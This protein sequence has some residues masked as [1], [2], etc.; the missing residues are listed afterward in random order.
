MNQKFI[1]L[2]TMSRSDVVKNVTCEM[3]PSAIIAREDE[4]YLT[5]QFPTLETLLTESIVG[6]LD[7]ATPH[8]DHCLRFTLQSS[9]AITLTELPLKYM[10]YLNERPIML[11]QGTETRTDTKELVFGG[12]LAS[13]RVGSNL[14]EDSLHCSH[15]LFH[16][17]IETG[18]VSVACI[19]Y[20]QAVI[21]GYVPIT[22]PIS[23]SVLQEIV[24]HKDP[25]L[26]VHELHDV[27]ISLVSLLRC[28]DISA[29]LQLP[30]YEDPFARSTKL[31]LF[32]WSKMAKFLRTIHDK[33]VK[34]NWQYENEYPIFE[35]ESQFKY[36]EE[37]KS[38]VQRFDTSLDLVVHRNTEFS[39]YFKP[40][41]VV[42]DALKYTNSDVSQNIIFEG[43]LGMKVVYDAESKDRCKVLPVAYED[44][45]VDM[46]IQQ[47]P[48]DTITVTVDGILSIP[49]V[50]ITAIPN[51]HLLADQY[52]SF[53]SN[54][55]PD[56]WALTNI[57]CHRLEL[58]AVQ[59]LQLN[60][61]EHITD[62]MLRNPAELNLYA[63]SK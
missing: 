55:G 50:H 29:H 32:T 10:F 9:D 48:A 17:N 25:S 62:M 15:V 7:V 47:S 34:N 33:S 61:V 16:A 60:S 12:I 42:D 2:E 4:E 56:Q 37:T 6:S 28:L 26:R 36:S 24:S 51:F 14:A 39:L 54:T 44:R 13:I 30:Q 23:L 40:A 1:L 3:W 21:H 43:N 8:P 20:D 11:Q 63:Q 31:S 19:P 45:L 27:T 41:R 58:M 35:L 59:K 46:Q 5:V 22:H 52:R 18:I 38:E 49:W 57:Y 53:L